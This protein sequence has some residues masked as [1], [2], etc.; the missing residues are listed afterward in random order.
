MN[1][2]LA[3]IGAN[4]F[5]GLRTTEILSAAAGFSVRPVVRSAS[6]LAVLARQPLDWRISS[7][8]ESAPLAE[9]L[10]GA[11]VCVH[12]AI[13]DAAQ[14][15][16]MAE[17]TYIACATAGVRRLVWLSSAS[18]H[19]QA[20]APGT[21]EATPLSDRQGL[22]YNN[23]KVRAEWALERLARDGRVEV[24]RLRP[25]V[26]FGP[27]SR[28]IA[29]AFA[30]LRAG[31]SVWLEGGRGLCNSIYID[32]LVEAIRLAAALPGISGEKFLVG[33]AETVTWRDF[34]LPIAAHAGFGADAFTEVPLPE[35]APEKE[36]AM[37]ALTQ[38]PVY[39]KL[40]RLMPERPK[41]MLKG[42]LRGWRPPTGG[43]DAWTWRHPQTDRGLTHELAEL[44]RCRWKFPH[45]HAARILQYTPLYTFAEG[46][47][48]SLAWADFAGI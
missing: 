40:G 1:P 6:S 3:I 28:W 23:A 19:G 13:G 39:G 21:T 5:V 41:R 12:A 11:E 36:D 34:L 42:L 2:T 30:D 10:R 22:L 47:R 8:A 46:Q 38:L 31:R 15:A 33:D 20:P 29:D 45:E 26:V 9:A 14:I 18:V 16:Q 35:F 27:R 25:G 43:V 32:N 48:R 7:F 4:G 24:V 44:Q 17:T 37:T